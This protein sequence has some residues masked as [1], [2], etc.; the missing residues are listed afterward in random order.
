VS[1]QLLLFSNRPE[2]IR[3]AVQG[4]AAGVV[5]DWERIGK[6]DRQ[7]GADTLIS[8]DTYED[9]EVA[10]A[11]TDGPVI[12]RLDGPGP[13]TEEEVERA[14]AAGADEVLLPMVRD[15]ADVQPAIVAAAGRCGVG[16]MIETVD[17]VSRVQELMSLPVCRAYVGL[18]D[19]SIERGTPSLFSALMD[20]TLE[21]VREYVR[22][23]PF[24]FGGS[25]L[26]DRGEP[27][28]ARLLLAEL[29]RLD[30]DF[31]F[32]RRSFWRDVEGRD[33]TAAVRAIRAASARMAAR[34]PAEVVAD[35]AQLESVL[36]AA[37]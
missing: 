37:A 16:V 12:C 35:R 1:L 4:G 5:I 19:L 29:D 30:A 32:L 34:T 25:T 7:R 31:T 21:H 9:L 26:P 3:A 15:P 36:V 20:G 13:W 2:L 18:N 6:E 17:A 14:I 10:R 27:V 33:A 28:P 23:V 8:A 11:T 24:G 22:G